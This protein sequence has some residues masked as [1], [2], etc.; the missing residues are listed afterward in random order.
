LSRV[1]TAEERL[2]LALS[3]TA[4][5]RAG[6]GGQLGELL[7]AL[8][9]AAFEACGRRTGVLSLAGTRLCE[10]GGEAVPS[11]FR[12]L[13]GALGEE[14]G[15]AALVGESV[16]ARVAAILE[17]QGVAAV[18][19]K[20]SA[21]AR[22]AYADP[23]LRSPSVD[24]DLLVRPDD[25]PAAIEALSHAGYEPPADALWSDG[26]P[27]LF[28]CSL[29]A[30]DDWLPTI[31][32]H[33]RTHWYETDFTRAL[34]DSSMPAAEGWRR[35]DPAY[36]LAALLLCFARDGFWG[37]RLPA[38]MAAWWEAYGAAM[39]G[40]LLDTVVAAHPELTPALVTACAVVEEI[41]GV[42]SAGLLSERRPLRRR[43]RRAARLA[44]WTG[45]GTT[46]E[47]LGHMSLVDW[48]LAPRGGRVAFL[49]RHLFL[50]PAVIVDV[51]ALPEGAR[52]R[53]A[54]RRLW[55][56]GVKF[57]NVGPPLL[58]AL[59]GVRG[60]RSWAPLPPAEAC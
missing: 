47:L 49:R 16:T 33:W 23:A 50:P 9:W 27:G 45:R 7:P 53:R 46:A 13:I 56:A 35:A 36:E 2:L 30:R 44:N 39:D 51:Y 55:Y 60:R 58:R 15:R 24:L 26:L 5:R 28:E 42:P 21:L 37:L 22:A 48:L 54:G 25:V 32:L 20:G 40:P 57:K 3:G 17:R 38:D 12:E 19:F 31:D 52:A 1:A 11:R 43:E 14:Y 59:W 4:A 29:R 8:D 18:P 34:V 6:A 41:V 10:L